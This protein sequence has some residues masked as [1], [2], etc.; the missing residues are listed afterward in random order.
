MRK[1]LSILGFSLIILIVSAMTSSFGKKKAEVFIHPAKMNVAYIGVENPIG[2]IAI[3]CDTSALIVTTSEGKIRNGKNGYYIAEFD[4]TSLGKT[5]TISVAMK[6]KGREQFMSSLKLRVKEVPLPQVYVGNFRFDAAVAPE[7]RKEMNGVFLRLQSFDFDCA[8]RVKSFTFSINE[9]G[10]WI[11]LPANGPNLTQQMK[12]K[13]N[14]ASPGTRVFIH[15]VVAIM[16][17][18]VIRKCAPLNL[19]LQ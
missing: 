13:I 5:I 1:S 6:I 7:L 2:I 19:T 18:N 12:Q 4:S 15:D 10:T 16:P 3:G 9:A 8:I 11:D 17:G 14:A